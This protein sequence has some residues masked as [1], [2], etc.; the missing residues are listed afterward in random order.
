MNGQLNGSTPT[1]PPGYLPNG[2]MKPGLLN[3]RA[4]VKPRKDSN[5]PFPSIKI[6]PQMLPSRLGSNPPTSHLNGTQDSPIPISPQTPSPIPLQDRTAIFRTPEGMSTFLDMDRQLDELMSYITPQQPQAS[7]SKVTL[8]DLQAPLGHDSQSSERR[9]A[10]VLK[11]MQSLNSNLR[12]VS[13][14]ASEREKEKAIKGFRTWA[15]TTEEAPL[16]HNTQSSL[17]R[18]SQDSGL[19]RK[20]SVS[21][22]PSDEQQRKKVKVK[23]EPLEAPNLSASPTPEMVDPLGAALDVWWKAVGTN[24][25]IASGVPSLSQPEKPPSHNP[26]QAKEKGIGTGK[27]KRD[28]E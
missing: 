18:L 21:L 16:S 17:S 20:R 15:S 3:G 22:T 8:N 2:K 10:M 25:M 9:E 13:D 23:S 14:S 11:L 24:R 26:I 7:T 1:P 4:I 27:R 28:L 12:N 6:P 19:K 5:S